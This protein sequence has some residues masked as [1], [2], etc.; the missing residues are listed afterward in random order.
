[1]RL[2]HTYQWNLMWCHA[3]QK[4]YM[5]H[6]WGNRDSQCMLRPAC[7]TELNKTDR[8]I[9]L[10]EVRSYVRICEK[11]QKNKK[12]TMNDVQMIQTTWIS[13]FKK[14]LLS[15]RNC[16]DQ[17]SKLF[18]CAGHAAAGYFCYGSAPV[19]VWHVASRNVRSGGF[20]SFEALRKAPG[21]SNVT[22]FVSSEGIFSFNVE[23]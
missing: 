17:K 7:C 23:L 14:R 8:T 2:W 4:R 13:V 20:K 19:Q 15:C 3:Y 22:F 5:L 21:Q 16:L 18:S 10:P 11:K 1:M 6:L 9:C 12:T